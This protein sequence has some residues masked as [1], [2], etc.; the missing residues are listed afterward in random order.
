MNSKGFIICIDD[1]QSV[2][3]Q[4]SGQLS[5]K[6][7]QSHEVE[8]AESAEEA[9][10]LI[11]ELMHEKEN[12]EFRPTNFVSD[13]FFFIAPKD[14]IDNKEQVK[15]RFEEAEKKGA[16]QDHLIITINELR[17]WIDDEIQKGKAKET[18]TDDLLYINNEYM[19]MLEQFSEF[20]KYIF[21][22]EK[23]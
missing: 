15:E 6:F 5:H 22:E 8:I 17:D 20:V 16:A 18:F 2:L 11:V 1:E 19:G 4:L 12:V 23:Q 21:N 10:E 7:G 14:C 9:M 13:V 3:N